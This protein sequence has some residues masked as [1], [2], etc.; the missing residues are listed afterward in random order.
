MKLFSPL[1]RWTAILLTV[2]CAS[3]LHAQSQTETEAKL[4]ALRET[5]AQLKTELDKIKSNRSELL[6]ELEGSESKMGELN[7]KV[8]A[9]QETLKKKQSELQQL[10]DKKEDAL[11]LKSSQQSAVSQALR[12][13]YQ[14]GQQSHIKLLINQQDPASASRHLKYLDYIVRSRNEKIEAFKETVNTLAELEPAIADAVYKIERDKN[15]IEEKRD[16]IKSTQDERRRTL[17]LI[18]K[19]IANADAKLKAL[20]KD[21]DNLRRLVE[22]VVEATDNLELAISDKPFSSLKGR[23]PW[24]TRGRLLKSF[25]STKVAGKLNWQ[26]MLIKAEEGEAVRA[27]HSG[28]VVFSDYLRGYGLLIIVDHGSGFMSLY[29]HNQS[30]YKSFGEWV[31]ANEQIATVGNSGGQEL[32]SLYFELRYKG[33]PTNPKA[34]LSRS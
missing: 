8:K 12:S 14:F 22:R 32:A 17:K 27:I 2:V 21:R 15:A 16:S 28:R 29:A 10:R 34:W 18:E 1:I 7:K 11:E 24:P 4:K 20:E 3:D 31:S 23:L 30:L 19:S 6:S 25:G 13:A 33:K 9:L 26:G 5:M